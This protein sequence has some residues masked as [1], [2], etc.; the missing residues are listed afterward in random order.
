MYNSVYAIRYDYDSQSVLLEDLLTKL[1]SLVDFHSFYDTVQAFF[2]EKRATNLR[3]E[4][5]S[6]REMVISFSDLKIGFKD[7]NFDFFESYYK[8]ALSSDQ[9]EQE[10]V[11]G[12]DDP[13]F[14]RESYHNALMSLTFR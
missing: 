1:V 10:L 7:D 6:G 14:D 2:D 11:L 9:I 13:S 3:Y 12:E 5:T 8:K 4:L